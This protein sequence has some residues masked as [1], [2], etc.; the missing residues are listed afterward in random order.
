MCYNAHMKT[1]RLMPLLAAACAVCAAYADILSVTPVP[2]N[3]DPNGWWMRRHERNVAR[4][5]AGGAPVVFIGD[6]ITH[7]W[8]TNGRAQWEKSFAEGPFRALNLGFSADRTEH[9]LWRLDH[10]ELDGYE[11]KAVVLMIGTNNTGHRPFAQEPPADTIIGVRAVLDK[12]RAKQPGA[13]IVLC[14]VFPR[15]ATARDACRLRND[16][17]NREIRRF[18]DGQTVLWCDFT[19]RFLAP[20]GTLPA[21]LFPDRLHPAAAGYEVWADGVRPFLEY[22]CAGGAARP[23]PPSPA[24]AVEPPA[25]QPAP[26]RAA[27][28]VG[29][30]RERWWKD[31]EMWF[32][33][34][35]RHRRAIAE[36]PRAYDLVLLGD[37]ITAG[38]EGAG[39]NVLAE[40]RKT[41]TV[42]PLGIGGDKVQHVL[43]RVRNGACDGYRAKLVMLM[44]GTNNNYGDRAE[45][46]ARGIE[47]V[48]AAIRAKQPQAKILLLPVFPRGERPD[49]RMRRN[50]AAVN[51]RIRGLADGE[52]VLWLDFTDRL[53][54][55]DGTI[56]K[57]LMP[58]F[59]HP[60]EAGYRIWAEAARPVFRAVCGK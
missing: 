13:K 24:P 26:T 23:C 38:W 45:D 3:A 53:V 10:G 59:L 36:G 15:G 4:A 7:F 27:A 48:L 25:T 49:D 18:A 43:W 8:E 31:P 17:V 28:L 41:Y 5:R 50:N 30:R 33:A 37:S 44:V 52:T 39:R 19:A 2:Q 46:T 42:L 54:Q 6:S 51:A 55:A 58:D 14:P 16:V 32:N 34:L 60:Q 40:L 11:A 20:D 47:A 1:K 9:V 21:A 35:R 57:A 22:A 56:S 12:I 29:V